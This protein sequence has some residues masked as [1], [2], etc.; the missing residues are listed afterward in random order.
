[1][2]HICSVCDKRLKPIAVI[3]E[4]YY[5]ECDWCLGE[6]CPTCSDLDDDTGL[7]KCWDCM[8]QAVIDVNNGRPAKEPL[9]YTTIITRE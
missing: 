8:E 3:D 9:I 1:M 5:R 2:R 6:V 4:A 7:V